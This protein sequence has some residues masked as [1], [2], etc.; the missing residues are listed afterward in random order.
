[1]EQVV[2]IIGSMLVLAAF[3]ATQRGWLKQRSTLYLLFNFVGSAVLTVAAIAG[4]QWGFLLLE[5][6][7]ALVSGAGLLAMVRGSGA[8][9]RRSGADAAAD[10]AVAGRSD[11]RQ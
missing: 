10:L 5:G 3:V 9:V 7:W 2:Q 11:L 1:M 8:D 4:S 6:V